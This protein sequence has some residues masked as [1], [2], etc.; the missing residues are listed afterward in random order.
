MKVQKNS[1]IE[2]KIDNLAY[3]G[4][5][6]GRMEGMVVFVPHA[7]PGDVVSARV[8]KKKPNYIEAEKIEILEPSLHRIEARCSL[9]GQCGGCSW[10]S[11]PYEKQLEFK[12]Q[13]AKSTLHHLGRQ[14][15]FKIHPILPSPEVWRYR[16]KVDY[17]FGQDENGKAVLGFHEPGSYWKIIDVEKCHIQPEIFDDLIDEMRKFTREYDLEP[18]HQKG[19]TGLMRHFMLRCAVNTEE[20]PHPTLAVLAT[21]EAELPH[22]DELVDRL[23]KRCPSLKG[24]IHG[25]NQSRGDV[26]KIQKKLFQWGEDFIMEKVGHL[27]LKVSAMSFFQTNSKAAENLYEKTLDFLELSGNES[28]FDAYCGAGAIAINCARNAGKVYGIELIK[29]AVWDARYNAKINNADNCTFLLGDMKRT[30][31]L[32]MKREPLGFSRVTVDPPRGG[33][34]KKS[35]RWIARLQAPVIVYV[36]CNPSTMARDIQSLCSKGYEI[37]EVQPVDMFPHTYHIEMIAHL[38]KT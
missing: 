37:T 30:L 24:F 22:R 2:V 35:L 27:K 1:V 38:K 29:D 5:G 6:I 4:R 26:F 20:E 9:F 12:E 33:M 3:G 10:Q 7:V 11:L 15:D 14:F 8:I 25:L 28:L 32:L 18:Y 31:P 34:D 17:T 13:I 19:H 16:N 23:R 21:G 36:S